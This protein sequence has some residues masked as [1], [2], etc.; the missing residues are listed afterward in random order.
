MSSDA[1]VLSG[2]LIDPIERQITRV[3]VTPNDRGSYLDSIK[4]LLGIDIGAVDVMRERL[5]WLPSCPKDDIW[6]DDEMLDNPFSFIVPQEGLFVYGKALILDWD[7]NGECVS[8]SLLDD[9][10]AALKSAGTF[11]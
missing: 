10:L 7:Q 3:E 4:N 9:D 11:L 8:T 1:K 6:V 2:V 5:E